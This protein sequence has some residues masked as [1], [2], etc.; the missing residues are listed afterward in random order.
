M[1]PRERDHADR[2]RLRLEAL[3]TVDAIGGAQSLDG[4][5]SL[6]ERTF[7]TFAFDHFIIAGIPMPHE[8]LERA[9]VLRNWPAGWIDMYAREDF[10]R[11]DPTVRMC[12]STTMPFEWSEAPVDPR[13]QRC[14]G[15]MDFARDFGL[16]RGF[17]LPVH[18]LNGS[19][20]CVSLGGLA[21]DIDAATKPALHLIAM[22]AFER[23]RGLVPE[24]PTRADVNPLTTREREV[25]TWSAVGKHYQEI[26]KIMNITERTVMA[27]SNNATHKL[28][29]ANKTQAVVRALQSSFI[30]I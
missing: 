2:R 8:Q 13:D 9:V 19:E 18:G 20:A 6:L 12:Q 23:A 14:Q 5:Y 4:L 26:A 16:K 24:A 17:S 21:P 28:G 7:H 30:R 11:V 25:L 29:A 1:A 3:D 27:H 22:Y 10:V 15:V